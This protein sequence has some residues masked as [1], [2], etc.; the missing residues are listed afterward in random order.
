MRIYTPVSQGTLALLAAGSLIMGMPVFADAT[1]GT[2]AVKVGK[3]EVMPVTAQGGD[4][5]MLV[6]S[7][8]QTRAVIG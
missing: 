5:L 2:L 6:E 4:M 1:S 7:Q 3:Q 8:A